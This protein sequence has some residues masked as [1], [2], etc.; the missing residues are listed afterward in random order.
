MGLAYARVK[1]ANPKLPELAPVEVDAL[2]DTGSGARERMDPN[3]A[4]AN[5]SSTEK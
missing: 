5:P 1:L 3:S 2:A 4:R